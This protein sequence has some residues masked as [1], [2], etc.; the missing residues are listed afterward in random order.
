MKR[1]I[2][3]P[4][5]QNFSPTLLDFPIK[6]I[7]SRKVG[8]WK[9]VS[10]WSC[11]KQPQEIGFTSAFLK[12]K[13]SVNPKPQVFVAPVRK[14]R[15]RTSSLRY[16]VSGK[17]MNDMRKWVWQFDEL[18]RSGCEN[19]YEIF[20]NVS[21]KNQ[22]EHLR[23]T[24]WKLYNVFIKY[25]VNSL[26]ENEIVKLIT[27]YRVVSSFLKSPYFAHFKTLRYLWY[28]VRRSGVTKS[29]RQVFK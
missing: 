8:I 21:F 22:H 3:N 17:T 13:W 9:V 1:F 14:R 20:K 4:I 28:R 7:S 10:S 2:Q 5:A 25:R 24:N 18:I 11:P 15:F 16:N 6:N 12:E 27:L 23:I 29:W 26:V 19:A